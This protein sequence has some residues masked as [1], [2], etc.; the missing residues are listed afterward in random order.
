[1]RHHLPNPL[2]TIAAI[3]TMASGAWCEAQSKSPNA[4]VVSIHLTAKGT[5]A[6]DE[7]EVAADKLFQA[8]SSRTAKVK[9]GGK[10]MERWPS[11][12]AIQPDR[13]GILHP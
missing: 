9:G 10:S 2:G 5:F 6:V 3:V 4:E 7:N 12:H 1:M 13:V 8:I 11:S